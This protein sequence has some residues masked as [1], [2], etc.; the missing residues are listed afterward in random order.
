MWLLLGLL[1]PRARP[2]GDAGAPDRRGGVGRSTWHPR[3]ALP[4]VALPEL[5]A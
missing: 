4:G 1:E 5:V 3:G 2:E